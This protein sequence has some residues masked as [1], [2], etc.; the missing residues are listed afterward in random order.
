MSRENSNIDNLADNES[1]K[2]INVKEDTD[3]DYG[4]FEL[5]DGDEA[6]TDEDVDD[7]DNQLDNS[8]TNVKHKKRVRRIKKLVL[9]V[10]IIF[11]L[12]LSATLAFLLIPNAKAKLL[13]TWIGKMM[14]K[15]AVSEQDFSNVQD[16]DFNDNEV[17]VNDNIDDILT[18]KYTNIVLLG[19][20]SRDVDIETS[21]RSDSI[22]IVSINK[23]SGEVRMASVY[24][25]SYLRIINNKGNAVYTKVNS[26]MTYSIEKTISTLNTNLD[27]NIKDYVVVN[28]SG[29]ATIIDKLGGIDITITAD[30]KRL[31]N[32]Y[33]K[34]TRKVT[35]MDAPDVTTYGDVHLTGLQ[36]TAYC[37]IRYVTFYAEDGTKINNDYGRAARQRLVLQKLVSKAKSAG[38]SQ[39][40]SIAEE[41]FKETS[42][43]K[44][45][46]TSL[47]YDEVM[48]LIPIVIDFKFGETTGFPFKLEGRN[49]Q[50]LN[51]AS[52]VVPNNLAENVSELHS[53]LFDSVNYVPS[54]TVQDISNTIVTKTGVGSK[55]YPN[56]TSQDET[57]T[58]KETTTNKETTTSKETTK[59][60]N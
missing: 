11:I 35:G 12:V 38:V 34:E 51:G 17:E 2:K 32:G 1:E 20:D 3:L 27:L 59:S 8:L 49:I 54:L 10:E 31:I 14:I 19:S 24:R 41:L 53:F 48:D 44:I 30:E 7:E 13:N 56:K 4:D 6:F 25:D 29:L 50:E 57:T 23:E 58:K 15:M 5:V 42:E 46:T 22:I 21:G 37:R 9:T 26:A 55:Y 39:I 52:C 45:M 16:T 18:D 28:F 43:E 33:L 36:A 60:N 47:T 40:M